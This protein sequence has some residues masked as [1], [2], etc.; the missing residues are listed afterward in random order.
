MRIIHLVVLL[1]VPSVSSLLACVPRQALR[2]GQE[3]SVHE[4][5]VS[6]CEVTLGVARSSSVIGVGGDSIIVASDLAVWVAF[7]PRSVARTTITAFDLAGTPTSA[8]TGTCPC[9]GA[10]AVD[11]SGDVFLSEIS[12]GTEPA[13]VRRLT[14]AGPSRWHA[15][16][17]M[18]FA[19]VSHPSP[20]GV[21]IDR[22]DASLNRQV[23]VLDPDTGR[24]RW[25]A[26]GLGGSLS[27][28]LMIVWPVSLGEV[29]LL[30]D[31]TG[32]VVGRLR[33]VRTMGEG[34]YRSGDGVHLVD[35]PDLHVSMPPQVEPVAVLGGALWVSGPGGTFEYD[36][37]T[38]DP[39]PLSCLP[40][41]ARVAFAH[42]VLAFSD[43]DGHV[44]IWEH[45]R[46]WIAPPGSLREGDYV[47]PASVW[48]V[49]A[50]FAFSVEHPRPD[51]LTGR[52]V[53]V[54]GIDP[55][56]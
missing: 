44:G 29:A 25:R 48:R 1:A 20:M 3:I 7:Q 4:A 30:Y 19:G 22:H 23:V 54:T 24:E 15:E 49:R 16:L 42:G 10:P 36:L 26:Q 45:G 18:A 32:T 38:G 52:A 43:E 11:G 41:G 35:H 6:P 28:S 9:T 50:G 8:V 55:E 14:S 33:D 5:A 12:D 21:P 39:N 2:S 40:A 31:Q 46:W 53:L 34:V 56:G 47:H 51:G 13:V 17:G 27:A 37:A